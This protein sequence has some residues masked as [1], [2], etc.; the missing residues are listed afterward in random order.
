MMLANEA[1]QREIKSAY[2]NL[3]RQWHPDKVRTGLTRDENAMVMIWIN[4]AYEKIKDG[5]N[6]RVPKWWEFQGPKK[7]KCRR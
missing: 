7:W 6:S 5:R 3:V 4:D 1:S 2:Q